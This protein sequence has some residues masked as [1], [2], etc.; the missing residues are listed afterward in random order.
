MFASLWCTVA[1]GPMGG[2]GFSGLLDSYSCMRYS[3]HIS[4]VQ[5]FPSGGL[6]SKFGSPTKG[7]LA[8][9]SLDRGARQIFSLTIES[10]LAASPGDPQRL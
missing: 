9:V 10:A 5:F 7:E 3:C 6:C 4:V 8:R 2:A 1:F